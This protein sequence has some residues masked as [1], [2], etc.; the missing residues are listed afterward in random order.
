VGVF[1]DAGKVLIDAAG[2]S[3]RVAA[4]DAAGRVVSCISDP[5]VAID[6]RGVFSLVWIGAAS[7]QW[8]DIA[9]IVSGAA[10]SRTNADLGTRRLHAQMLME[11]GFTEEALSRLAAIR[12]NPALSA[13]D[14][15]QVFGHVGRIYK[16][17][18]VAAASAREE[19]AAGHLKQALEGGYW[20]G[21]KALKSIWLGINAVALLARPEAPAV[22]SGASAEAAGIAQEIL[23]E[24][25]KLGDRYLDATLAEA[26]IAI[27]RMD[28]A[29]ERAKVYVATEGVTGF[30]LNNL[31]RQLK[32]VWRLDTMPSPGPEMLAIVGAALLEKRDG[33]LHL[34]SGDVARARGVN[35]EAVFGADR[36]DSMENYR[37]GLERCSCVAR[38]GRSVEVGVGTGFVLPGRVLSDKLD[39]RF[40]LMTN[41][42]VISESDAE[43]AGG[44]LHPSEAVVT[45]A[46]LEGVAPDKEFGVTKILCSSPRE[47]LDMVIVELSEPVAPKVAYPLAPVLPVRGTQAQVRVIGHP[48]GRGLSLS[49]N[50][51]LDY[52]TPKV[53][54]RTAT[55]GG[56]SGSPVFNQ[57][58]KLIGIHHAGGDAVPMLNGKT[59]TYQANEGIWIEAIS[60][61][62]QAMLK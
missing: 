58:W 4:W 34:S 46:A 12:Q 55:E 16:D 62:V 14:R 57:E 10:A 29:L 32:Q 37:R 38:V 8:F 25:P 30:M 41:A 24:A 9:E 2:R 61:A 7:H 31:Y 56:S 15:E 27:G 50:Q 23:V 3:D 59:G 60:E 26:Y 17:R 20:A 40:V 54:Y 36:F 28:A 5:A 47:Q 45:F 1:D 11:R 44:A 6:P 51:L 52:E 35:Y 48:S 13:F 39:D 18:F 49:V 42:H 19:S 53:H 21:Y 22:V 33:V 43:R